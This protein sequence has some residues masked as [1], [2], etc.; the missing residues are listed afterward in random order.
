[1]ARPGVLV[2]L[3]LSSAGSAGLAGEVLSGDLDLALLSLPGR[4][5]AGLNLAPVSAE[6]LLLACPAPPCA[7]LAAGGDRGTAGR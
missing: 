7:R 1:V 6:Q 3:R 5:P 4:P 2:R